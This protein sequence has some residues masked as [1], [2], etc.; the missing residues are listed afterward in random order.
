MLRLPYGKKT[1]RTERFDFEEMPG[2]P[3]HSD[4][5]WGNPAFACVY[6]IAQSFSEYGWDMRA[7][8]IQNIEGLPLHVYQDDGESAIKP[9]AEILMLVQ[10][11]EAMIERGLMPLI[12]MKDSDTVRVGM[13]Q[14]IAGRKLPGRWRG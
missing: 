8:A 3:R 12:T 13:F 1:D 11:A 14:S 5:L 7:G 2:K 9:C 10:A 4:Y 6:L